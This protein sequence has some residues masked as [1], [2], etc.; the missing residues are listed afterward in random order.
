MPHVPLAGD[1]GR[2]ASEL[3]ALFFDH[4]PAM[5]VSGFATAACAGDCGVEWHG[6]GRI[7]GGG[8]V[9]RL[10]L[11]LGSV[12]DRYKRLQRKTLHSTGIA[13]RGHRDEP[14][15]NFECFIYARR[16]W[17]GSKRRPEAICQARSQSFQRWRKRF[18]TWIL[19]L[20][21]T[22]PLTGSVATLQE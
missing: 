16:T 15:F 7:A 21:A 13:S 10:A 8:C 6:N 5:S 17:N 19:H 1:L 14:W 3:C 18:V 20:S 9:S 4:V 11:Q 12:A 2:E 22:D